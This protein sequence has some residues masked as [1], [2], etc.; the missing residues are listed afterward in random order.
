MIWNHEAISKLSLSDD[1]FNFFGMFSNERAAREQTP[2]IHIHIK[3][4]E[5][6]GNSP[7]V[8]SIDSFA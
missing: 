7:L 4:R 2:L 8:T 3:L 5:G 6:L 1:N